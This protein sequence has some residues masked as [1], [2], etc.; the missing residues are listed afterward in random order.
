MVN[1]E[2]IDGIRNQIA[3]AERDAKI[4]RKNGEN[5]WVCIREI[6]KLRRQLKKLTKV[7][8]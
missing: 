8:D 7:D 6:R 3:F 5:D 1:D 2:K 4:L